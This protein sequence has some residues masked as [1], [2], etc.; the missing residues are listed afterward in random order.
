[1]G[2][3][4]K[5]RPF[6]PVFFGQALACRGGLRVTE[7]TYFHGPFGA[8]QPGLLSLA[9]RSID[10]VKPL[11]PT[12]RPLFKAFLCYV[13]L[14]L[15]ASVGV[16]AAEPVFD[17]LAFDVEGN[18]VLSSGQV[19]AAVLPFLGER[20]GMKD[21]E[22]A[23]A[24][25]EQ[26][27]Q[28]AGYLTVLVDVPEQR[29]DDGVVRL[30]VLEG[31]VGSQYV[32]GSRY[33]SQGWIRSRL[34]ALA[35]GEVPDFNLAQKQLAALSRGDDRTVQ[36]VL[37]PGRVPGTVDL[38]LQVRD[39]LPVSGSVELNNNH[40]HDTDATRMSS[41]VRYDNFLQRDHAVAVTW[42]VAPTAPQQSRV[43]IGTY[44]APV[45]DQGDSLNFSLTNS[46]SNVEPLG[47]TNVVA[48]GRT[49]S[50]RRLSGWSSSNGY[51][52]LSY[53]L[54]FK[55]LRET[56]AL[57]TPVRYLPFQVSYGDQWGSA[58]DRF[59]L[60]ATG[61]VAL[62]QL[63]QRNILCPKGDGT[64]FD[65]QFE[66]K[67][68]GA[69]GSFGTLKLD[70]RWQHRLTVDQTLAM[71]LGGQFASGPLISAEQFSLGGAETVRGYYEA[72]VSGDRAVL[73]SVEWQGAN[74]GA[75]L[76][77]AQANLRP[78][79][80]ADAARSLTLDALA[81][82]A[83]STWLASTG[84]GLRMNS[85]DLDMTLDMGVPLRPTQFSPRGELRL[86]ARAVARF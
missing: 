35:P 40:S 1:L 73:G 83:R 2:V 60:S 75:E 67:R 76:P 14:A 85:K 26:V 68:T 70:L 31:R 86:H 37:R 55:D 82:Q 49:Y 34:T 12:L 74:W 50:L 58:T 71:R 78:T 28:Q 38:D 15:L 63:F 69:S 84:A 48:A 5:N 51:R 53:G 27:Y 64:E 32:L 7:K 65:D 17:I 6:R 3:K 44:T 81:G 11:M 30:S 16:R 77:L 62:R 52:T 42:M 8:W 54:D 20:R 47:S 72:E 59:Q 46:N 18:T 41:T 57:A 25:L 39:R 4:F 21:V 24:A 13:T 9:W 56:A 29:I 43:L 33:H 23:R 66:C 79:V 36:P 22:G 45:G 10:T 61:T 80:C 19:E